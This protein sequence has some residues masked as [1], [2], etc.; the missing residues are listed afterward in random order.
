MYDDGEI[1]SNGAVSSSTEIWI[2]YVVM[3]LFG[4]MVCLRMVDYMGWK[5]CMLVFL[6]GMC[7]CNFVMASVVVGYV[8]GSARDAF[9]VVIILFVFFYGFGM[10]VI[11][12]FI[13]VELFF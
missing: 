5:L 7:F 4:I 13:V 6:V 1:S 9:D 8:L 3:F 2:V 12:M 11:L 10:V